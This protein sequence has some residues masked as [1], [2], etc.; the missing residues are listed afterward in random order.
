M[1]IVRGE[2]KMWQDAP[3]IHTYDE[4]NR[5]NQRLRSELQTLRARN[6]QIDG[7]KSSLE[8]PSGLPGRDRRTDH[9]E[10]G[11]EDRLWESLSA[12]S[13]ARRSTVSGW[14]DVVLPSRA[15][16]EQ[17]TAYDKTWNSWVHYAVEYPRFENECHGFISAIEAG[18]PIESYDPSWMAVY[19]SVLSAALLMMGDDEAE[20]L[21]LPGGPGNRRK[22]SR[23]WYDTAIFALTRADFMRVPNIRTIQATAVLGMCFNTWGDIELGQHMW[24]SSLLIAQRINLNTP[25]SRAAGSCLGEEAQH[26]LWWTLVIC[27]WLNLPYQPPVID[28]I[29]FDVP[30]PRATP[31]EMGETIYG[32]V[33]YHIFMARAATVV[34]HFRARIRSGVKSLDELTKA[35]R[36]ADDELA[37]IIETLPLHLQPDIEAGSEEL[38]RLEASQPWIKWQRYDLTLVLLHLR[39]RLHRTLQAQ[40]LSGHDYDWAKAVSVNSAMSVIWINRNWDQPS[41]LRK[42]WYAQS[43]IYLTMLCDP[44]L[45][46]VRALSHHIFVSA[47]LLLRQCRVNQ[48]GEVEEYREAIHAAIELL[49]SVKSWNMLAK[50]AAEI[51]R[52]SMQSQP[53]S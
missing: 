36:S 34:Y 15:C 26:R 11:L 50:Y 13:T 31:R 18:S 33:H 51:L 20:R 45:D 25:Y 27:E 37:Q 42:Q 9:D 35:V 23:I 44:Y 29:D 5:E 41:S 7:N 24:R 48:C 40:W 39:L 28:D 2:V 43:S 30:L 22:M 16:S 6:G 1:V 46:W 38:R 4:L 52:E 49:E 3:H 47:I 8:S 21:L 14:V 19:F 53:L 32:Q 17:L 10:E 12:A